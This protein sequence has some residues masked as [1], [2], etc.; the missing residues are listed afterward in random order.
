[1]NSQLASTAAIT[2]GKKFLLVHCEDVM[3]TKENKEEHGD[4]LMDLLNEN[5]FKFP[6]GSVLN[7]KGIDFYKFTFIQNYAPN[8]TCQLGV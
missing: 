4:H 6:V 5:P 8:T 7:L 3:F 2:P 1:L